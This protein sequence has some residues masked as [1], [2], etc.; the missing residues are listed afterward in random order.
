MVGV[1][2]KEHFYQSLQKKVIELSIHIDVDVKDRSPRIL[3]ELEREELHFVQTLERG[4]KLLDEMLVDALSR[5]RENGT[6]PCLSGKDA[7]LLYNTYG[8]PV[9][10]TK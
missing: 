7:F 4:E 5:A 8:F 9:E 3:G 10:I 1:T 6:A 2:L